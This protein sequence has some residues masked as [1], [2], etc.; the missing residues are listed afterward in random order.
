MSA[1]LPNQRFHATSTPPLRSGAAAREARR[2]T[3]KTDGAS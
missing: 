1:L 2:W 3:S